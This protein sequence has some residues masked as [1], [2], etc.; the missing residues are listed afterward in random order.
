MA[1][2][3]VTFAKFGPLLMEAIAEELLEY[4]NELRTRDGLPAVPKAEF[5]GRLNNNINHLENYDWMDD[6]T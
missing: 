4:V 5:L 1:L 3:D 2:R 6:G